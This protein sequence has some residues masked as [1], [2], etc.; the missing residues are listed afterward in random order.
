M[1]QVVWQLDSSRRTF[2]PRLGGPLTSI[3]RSAVDA[4]CYVISQAD[5]TVR[6]VS[7]TPSLPCASRMSMHCKLCNAQLVHVFGHMAC[8]PSHC[9]GVKTDAQ[10]T[11]V[12]CFLL[13]ACWAAQ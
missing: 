11:A 4:A 9:C 6:M 1:L 5:N 10:S 13:Q 8:Y 12:L 7:G 3:T 2:L